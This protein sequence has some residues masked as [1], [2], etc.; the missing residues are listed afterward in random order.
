MLADYQL[1]E[2]CQALLGGTF[3]F[4]CTDLTSDNKRRMHVATKELFSVMYPLAQALP[5]NKKGIWQ[6]KSTTTAFPKVCLWVSIN[7]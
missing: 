5:G 4:F 7:E 3:C 1:E 6:V 2:Q